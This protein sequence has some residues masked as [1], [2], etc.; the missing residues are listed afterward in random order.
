MQFNEYILDFDNDRRYFYSLYTILITQL[1]KM[2]LLFTF[3]G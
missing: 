1:W 3:Y 2:S